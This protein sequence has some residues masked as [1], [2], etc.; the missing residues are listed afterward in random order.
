[1]T[2]ESKRESILFLIATYLLTALAWGALILLKTPITAGTASFALYLLGGLS[3]TIVALLLPL[4]AAKGERKA[5][6]KRYFNFN[7]SFKW[8]L[9][10]VAMVL[11]MVFAAFLLTQIFYKQSAQN[12]TILPWYMI[13]PM[14]VQMIVGGGL[15]E[16]GWR[17]ILVHHYQKKNLF[18]T[19]LV[20]GIIWAFWHIPLFFM[21]G[22]SQFIGETP[23][24]AAFLPFFVNVIGLS[25]VTAV[26]YIRSLS[27]VPCVIF[28]AL[29]NAMS[30]MGFDQGGN[31]VTIIAKLVIIAAFVFAFGRNASKTQ[32]VAKEAQL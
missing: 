20:I 22:T 30:G 29:V 19:A 9:V 10:P 21:T 25:F 8:Y 14:F 16:L 5:Y 11:V 12:L 3:P 32:L 13:F 1:M 27:V 7:I 31:T 6:Y 23:F 15:E 17:G 2:L 26:L 18:L 28:H 24:V 4:R